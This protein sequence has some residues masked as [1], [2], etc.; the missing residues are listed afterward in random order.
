MNIQER[1]EINQDKESL[2]RSEINNQEFPGF[3]P[4]YAEAT[5]QLS[6]METKRTISFYIY[7]TARI[8]EPIHSFL[9]LYP[10]EGIKFKGPNVRLTYSQLTRGLL[11]NALL[12]P[13][14]SI[15]GMIA[16]TVWFLPL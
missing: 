11:A 14:F 6:L 3:A 1:K 2:E 7:V 9:S 15:Y 5:A 13:N 12:A 8:S 4:K 16:Y 10:H